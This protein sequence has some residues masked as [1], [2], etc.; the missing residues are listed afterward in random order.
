MPVN[1]IT[2]PPPP[3]VIMLTPAET[4]RT[5]ARQFLPLVLAIRPPARNPLTKI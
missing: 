1:S 5:Q 4:K 3:K 2:K